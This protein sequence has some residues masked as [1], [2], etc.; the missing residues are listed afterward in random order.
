MVVM[1]K[2]FGIYGNLLLTALLLPAV[3]RGS[4]DVLGAPSFD[5]ATETT[6]RAVTWDDFKG[7]GARPPGWSRW[8]QS[9][10]AHIATALRVSKY[11]V[12]ERQQDGEWL[13]T[14]VGF[15]PYAIMN[16]DF[17]A[18]KHG[19]RNPYTLNH[20]QLHFDIAETKAR[21]LAVELADFTGR[22][23]SAEEAREDLTRRFQERLDA[24]IKE[25]GEL[26]DRYDGETAH[27]SK[28]KQQKKWAASVPEMFRQATAALVALLEEEAVTES[29]SPAG[30]G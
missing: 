27:G 18:V 13:A 2:A 10:F 5:H 19:S 11:R 16:K 25:L 24:G 4:G 3:A 22:G 30:G 20:E 26:Q 12:E 29:P 14:A 8:Q 15:R 6:Y 28:K 1:G 21:Q 17:S 9:S 23:G 7:K